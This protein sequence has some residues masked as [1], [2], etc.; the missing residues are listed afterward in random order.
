MHVVFYTAVHPAALVSGM[1][2]STPMGA[3]P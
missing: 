1:W 2:E 3:V